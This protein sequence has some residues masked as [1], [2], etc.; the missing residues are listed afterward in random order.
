MTLKNC[1]KMFVQLAK[2]CVSLWVQSDPIFHCKAE[3][4]PMTFLS[5]L[6]GF[7][8]LARDDKSREAKSM[9]TLQTKYR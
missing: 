4:C 9:D 1:V 8:E 2:T 3:V 6:D 5:K 7:P